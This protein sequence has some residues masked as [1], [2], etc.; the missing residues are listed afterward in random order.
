MPKTYGDS[1]VHVSQIDYFVPS[2]RQLIEMKK[3]NIGEVNQHWP[4]F[5]DMVEDGCT[6]QFGMG[7]I[8]NAIV[9]FLKEKNDLG[10][11]SNSSLMG[12]WN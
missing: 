10:I 2:D 12:P 6:M 5:A 7:G 9:G 1:L 8:P 3:P 4:I 11:H